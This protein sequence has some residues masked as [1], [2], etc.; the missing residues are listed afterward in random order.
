M[1][2]YSATIGFIST[3][4]YSILQNR[5]KFFI[6]TFVLVLISC[7][8]ILLLKVGRDFEEVW[9]PINDRLLQDRDFINDVFG[10]S[11]PKASWL[12]F[13]LGAEKYNVLQKEPLQEVI[14]FMTDV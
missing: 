3:H 6:S 14:N 8:G 1:H 12:L 2:I 9:V 7:L 13:E 5:K 4:A 11:R 10:S